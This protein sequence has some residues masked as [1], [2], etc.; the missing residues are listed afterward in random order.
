MELGTSGENWDNG[1]FIIIFFL[2]IFKKYD[3]LYNFEKV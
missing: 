3:W 2:S 1:F